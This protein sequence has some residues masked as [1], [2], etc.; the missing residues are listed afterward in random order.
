MNSTDRVVRA[1]V[2]ER[3]VAGSRVVD[4]SSLG[5]DREETEDSLDRLAAEHRLVLDDERRVVMAHPFSGVDTGHTATIGDRTYWANCA[6]DALALLALLGDGVARCPNGIEWYVED[7]V[8]SPAG[9]IHLLVPAR[10]FWD[11]VVFT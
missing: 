10:H 2:Y 3:F 9:F 8:V 6:W 1:R 4:P 7:G 11:D 5:L